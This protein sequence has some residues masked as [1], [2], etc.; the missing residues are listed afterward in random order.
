MT[1]D[2]DKIIIGSSTNPTIG[3]FG[4]TPVSQDTTSITGAQT[5]TNTWPGASD[6]N[7]KM[8][9]ACYTTLQKLGLHQ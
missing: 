6:K 3:F 2:A 8:L 9:Q 7:M 4:Y 1:L 5:A